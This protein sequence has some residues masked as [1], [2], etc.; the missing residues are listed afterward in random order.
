MLVRALY[1]SSYP[2]PRMGRTDVGFFS[3]DG[4]PILEEDAD[5]DVT[6]LLENGDMY[7]VEVS[8]GKYGFRVVLKRDNQKAEAV[9][10]TVNRLRMEGV[11]DPELR[12]QDRPAEMPHQYEDPDEAIEAYAEFALNHGGGSGIDMEMDEEEFYGDWEEFEF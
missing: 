8:R 11:M 2:K 5:E 1:Q 3:E 4:L 9:A 7:R 12:M 6:E 10:E